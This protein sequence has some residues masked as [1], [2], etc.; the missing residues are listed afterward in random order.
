MDRVGRKLANS[1]MF[2]GWAIWR[3]K[4]LE[5]CHIR[6]FMEDVGKKI[7]NRDL[8]VGW[9]IWRELYDEECRKMEFL[10]VAAAT[11]LSV[12]LCCDM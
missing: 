5:D 2:W 3:D 6:E 11:S 10:Q 4:Y 7:A 12:S 8:F 9:S 1:D